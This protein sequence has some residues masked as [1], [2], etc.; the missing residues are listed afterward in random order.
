MVDFTPYLDQ[1]NWSEFF[2]K[3]EM[4]IRHSHWPSL[5]TQEQCRIKA[6]FFRKYPHLKRPIDRYM[7][8]KI[9]NGDRDWARQRAERH[10]QQQQSDAA[11]RTKSARARREEEDRLAGLQV[12]ALFQ[13]E[14][15]AKERRDSGIH[16]R[17]EREDASAGTPTAPTM[18]FIPPEPVGLRRK[19][20][21]YAPL[22]YDP[23]TYAVL[24]GHPMPAARWR[25]TGHRARVR[26]H[27]T[28]DLAGIYP[29]A[30][31]SDNGEPRFYPQG[32]IRQIHSYHHSFVAVP[33][34]RMASEPEPEGTLQDLP[35]VTTRD[36]SR[37]MALTGR[38]RR[39]ERQEEGEDTDM[40]EYKDA[41][42]S[43]LR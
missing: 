25:D 3:D 38:K 18:Q 4:S 20:A 11:R 15:R 40:D 5:S 1:L 24:P 32:R 23:P 33:P 43:R 30:D 12:E 6:Q 39:P 26:D 19:H 22:A 21:D 36:T 8:R 35:P 9:D 31:T 7:P 41:K 2:I 10:I 37:I 29:G 28:E 42:R 27:S 16:V 17:A 14:L 34:F 13:A